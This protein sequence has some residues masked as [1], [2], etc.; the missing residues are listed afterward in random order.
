MKKLGQEGLAH[1][2]AVLIA[3][4][5][6][7]VIGFTGYRVYQSK[8]TSEQPTANQT[9]TTAP[10]RLEKS[11]EHTVAG[12]SLWLFAIDDG[13]RQVAVSAEEDQQVMLGRLDPQNPTRPVDWRVAISKADASG[14]GVADHWHIFAHGVHWIAYSVPGDQ[15]SYLA[16]FDKDFKRTNLVTIDTSGNVP[17]NDMFLVAEKDGVAVGHFLP[18]QGHKI[19][20][21]DKNA[22]PKGTV[23]VGG[24]QYSHTNGS[25]AEMTENGFIIFATETL[26]PDAEGGVKKIVTDSNWKP[27]SATNL[28]RES[29]KNIVMASSAS[30]G[31]GYRVVHAR[32]REGAK[33]GP[34]SQPTPG[35]LPD[36]S[37]AIVRYVI[38]PDDKV[39]SQE[40]LVSE[41]ANRPHTLLVNNLL[42]TT[43]D[44]KSGV[45]LRIDKVSF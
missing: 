16:T 41:G 3:V 43:W 12:A 40:V 18:G 42:I 33:S 2:L 23:D 28:L 8:N 6:V 9:Q 4:V 30:L 36:D 26:A 22:K 20:R 24:G 35:P 10:P 11:T 1:V 38:S 5:I 45:K 7:G 29:G 32:V 17:T 37:G 19:F 27:S 13:S 44:S 39:V 34:P 15:D 31:N 25:S 14:R 21:F